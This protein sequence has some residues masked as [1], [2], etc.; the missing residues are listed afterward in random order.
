MQNKKLNQTASSE[1][2]KWVRV[3]QAENSLEANIIKGLLN[4]KGIECQLQGEL[5]QGA[6]GEIPF[7]QTG[8]D[9]LVYAL[10]ERQAQEILLNYRQLK[11]SAPDWVCP[12]CHELNGATFEICWSC[13]TVKNYKS[14]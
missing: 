11:Q 6:L 13:G 8:V 2:F 14:E 10:K 1:P 4:S 3:F 12:K 9:M 7:E 5:L